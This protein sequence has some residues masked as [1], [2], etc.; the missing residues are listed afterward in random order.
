MNIWT[1]LRGLV[2][3]SISV[4]G[5]AGTVKLKI[6]NVIGEPTLVALVAL[7]IFTGTLIAFIDRVQSVSLKELKMTLNEVK[8]TEASVKE[9]A[10]A[11]LAVIESQSHGVMLESYDEQKAIKAIGKLEALVN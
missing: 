5:V 4:F 2:G 7:A 6:D 8:E 3:A 1:F 9:V 11:I 10:R